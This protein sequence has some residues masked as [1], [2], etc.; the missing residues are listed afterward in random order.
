MLKREQGAAQCPCASPKA[1]CRLEL[2]PADLGEA[3]VAADGRCALVSFITSPLV[4]G[5]ENS[6]VLFVTDPALAAA[7]SAFEW[8]FAESDGAT[9]THITQDGEILYRPQTVGALNV[10][11]RILDVGGTE[12]G[13]LT[14]G[15]AIVPLNK[16]LE[17]MISSKQDQSGPAIGNIDVARELVN[18]HNPYYQGAAPQAAEEGD[19]FRHLVFGLVRNGALQSP[20]EQRKR[21]IGRLAASL[22]GDDSDFPAL[23]GLGI[24]VCGIR[25][26]LLAM[27][28]PQAA[29]SSTTFLPWTELP[30]RQVERSPAEFETSSGLHGPRRARS[31]RSVQ[32][33]SLP[34]KQHRPM[35]PHRR[36]APQ[37]LFSWREFSGCHDR[38][39]R[40]ACPLDP[41]T[42]SSRASE[43][44]RNVTMPSPES[45]VD[46]PGTAKVKPQTPA[47]GVSDPLAKIPIVAFIS[48]V[49][50]V[51]KSYPTD[52]PPQVLTR[53]RQQYY[54][55]FRFQ[56]LIP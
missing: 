45:S 8:T 6:Y 12:A 19:A 28:L 30:E 2:E 1:D 13:K 27:S 25:L 23:V 39:V 7:A 5:R 42:F 21:Q 11:V 37:P 35:R 38:H 9:E 31:A 52:K 40:H 50:I 34:E 14:L 17:M 55:D 26:P 47:A 54:F 46:G 3:T 56:R 43:D 4:V 22:N 53:I 44:G 10:T 48:Y 36:V 16:E 20:P 41:K 32:Y 49:E 51:E 29:G 15:Q 24:G 18:D 33:G